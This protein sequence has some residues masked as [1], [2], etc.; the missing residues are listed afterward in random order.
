MKTTNAFRNGVELM[1]DSSL[2]ELK[3]ADGTRKTLTVRDLI[4]LVDY[5]MQ[6]EATLTEVATVVALDKMKADGKV[7]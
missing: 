2:C 1:A 4:E 5:A 7:H 3:L 6:L